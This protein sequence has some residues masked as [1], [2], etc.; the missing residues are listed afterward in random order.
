MLKVQVQ[1]LQAQLSQAGEEAKAL[2][3]RH[4]AAE[5]ALSEKEAELDKLRSTHDEG[6]V[7]ANRTKLRSWR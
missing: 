3:D 6:S 2:Q 4:D 5:R 1:T 7:A